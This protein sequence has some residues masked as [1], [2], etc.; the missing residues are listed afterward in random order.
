MTSR[1]AKDSTSMMF[2]SLDV[3]LPEALISS[4]TAGSSAMLDAFFASGDVRWS[5]QV[6][7]LGPL[8]VIGLPVAGEAVVEEFAVALDM[9][10]FLFI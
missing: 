3:S 5:A 7:Y 8:L 4:I 10:L 9:V 2:Q 6:G 1:P